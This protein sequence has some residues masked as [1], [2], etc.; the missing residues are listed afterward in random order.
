[1]GGLVSM[2]EGCAALPMHKV[3]EKTAVIEVPKDKFLQS[4]VVIIR[5]P[6]LD[7][8]L[9]LVKSSEDLYK[10]LYMKCTHEDQILTATSSGLHC[11]AH[12][13]SFDLDGNVTKE[14]ALKPLRTFQTIVNEHSISIN[15]KS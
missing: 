11:A 5:T 15:L 4:S 3:S 9:L 8:D 12:G 1:M 10:A 7:Y 14:P 13:S 2:L 6:W